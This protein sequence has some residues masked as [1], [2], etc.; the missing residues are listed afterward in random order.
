VV[1]VVEWHGRVRVQARQHSLHQ[2]RALLHTHTVGSAEV[3]E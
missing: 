3:S 2:H 1:E